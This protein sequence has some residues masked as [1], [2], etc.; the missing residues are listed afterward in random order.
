MREE[1]VAFLF[2]RSYLIIKFLP[3]L[4]LNILDFAC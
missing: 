3:N 4:E 2:V 1:V